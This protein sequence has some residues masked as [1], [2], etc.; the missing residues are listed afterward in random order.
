[1]RRA[2]PARRRRRRHSSQ[3][4]EA[5]AAAARTASAIG[6]QLV[7]SS[8]AA[9]GRPGS[10]GRSPPRLGGPALPPGPEVVPSSLGC[11]RGGAL[12]G[13]GSNVTQPMSRYQTSTHEWASRSRT[14]YSRVF[15][16]SEPEV[17]PVTTRDGTPAIRSSS[18]I[19]PENCWQ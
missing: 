16:S 5:S 8:G 7:P 3:P 6:S 11:E 2:R 18:A 17:K 19:A 1:V 15:V 14:T 10:A 9:P 13:V 4:P 12:A